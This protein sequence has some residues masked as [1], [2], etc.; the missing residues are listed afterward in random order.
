VPIRRLSH[1]SDLYNLTYA[2]F[3]LTGGTL[4]D[5]YGRHRVFVLGVAVFSVGTFICAIAPSG[6]VLVLDRGVAGLGAALQLPIALAI[7]NVTY[8]DAAERAR[9][10][11]IWGG[12][13]R[14]GDRSQR[15]RHPRRHM[16][17]A[18]SF[19]GDSSGRNHYRGARDGPLPES[20]GALSISRNV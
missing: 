5:L 11:A 10:I 12:M 19:L 4:G 20:W 9:A 13:A 7:L 8:P 6:G 14:D 17:L 2:V 1:G 3:I 16:R 18:Q 15:R